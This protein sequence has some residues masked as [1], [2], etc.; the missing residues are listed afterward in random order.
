M[1]ELSLSDIESAFTKLTGADAARYEPNSAFDAALL[2]ESIRAMRLLL[3]ADPDLEARFAW[4]T[5]QNTFASGIEAWLQH[6]IIE[7]TRALPPN[8]EDKPVVIRISDGASKDVMTLDAPRCWLVVLNSRVLFAH[9]E[10]LARMRVVE[11]QAGEAYDGDD[12]WRRTDII[13]GGRLETLARG[14]SLGLGLAYAQVIE[15]IT[16]M[17]SD[18]VRDLGPVSDWLPSVA[19]LGMHVARIKAKKL[20]E[21]QVEHLVRAPLRFAVFH[22]WG[23]FITHTFDDRPAD[24]FWPLS[25]ADVHGQHR[26]LALDE[27]VL[28]H[29][30]PRNYFFGR[31]G[32]AVGMA[33]YLQL[34]RARMIPAAQIEAARLLC[35]RPAS[36]ETPT[37]RRRGARDVQLRLHNAAL[38]VFTDADD[39]DMTR[40]GV[41]AFNEM[42][43]FAGLVAAIV[44]I[45]LGATVSLPDLCV[46]EWDTV[47]QFIEKEM[48]F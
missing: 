28:I 11:L 34:A 31:A 10:L 36:G 43:V 40:L 22:G 15:W 2:S 19:D 21:M 16:R 3:N 25:A 32:P 20:P 39:D 6:E 48:P 9:A 13:G 26:L 1:V 17:G 33:V 42:Q 24:D 47:R 44:L 23:T 29:G 45:S 30:V 14:E 37:L 41:A 7:A 12:P 18:G 35:L 4:I 27:K 38:H 5:E 8:P 46:G